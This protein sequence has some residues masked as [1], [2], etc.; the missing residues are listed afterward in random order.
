MAPGLD[1]P[2][3]LDLPVLVGSGAFTLLG[4]GTTAD[5][6][7]AIPDSVSVGTDVYLQPVFR[8]AVGANVGP[9]SVVTLG[10]DPGGD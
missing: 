7:L 10:P 6:P 2:L 8:D 5:V 9:P 4:G 3:A 1:G